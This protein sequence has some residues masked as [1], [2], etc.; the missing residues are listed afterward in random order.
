MQEPSWIPQH[1]CE[2]AVLVNVEPDTS[3]FCKVAQVAFGNVPG[4]LQQSFKIVS[5]SR[6]QNKYL[7]NAYNALANRVKM[8]RY[9]FFFRDMLG[10]AGPATLSPQ[11]LSSPLGVRVVLTSVHLL[12]R[13]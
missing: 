2:P 5:F 12:H 3:D 8:S 7:T 10:N 6:V 13:I 9:V 1:P 4:S 11:H